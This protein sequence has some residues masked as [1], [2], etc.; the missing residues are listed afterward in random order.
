MNRIIKFALYLIIFYALFIVVA[1]S[2]ALIRR[3]IL[4][5]MFIDT[6]KILNNNNIT[7]W[8]DFG[9][10]LGIHRDQNI[11]LGDNDVDICI[12]ISQE[13]KVYQALKNSSVKW[14]RMHWPAFRV[15]NWGFWVDLYL[16]TVDVKKSMVYIPDSMD[17]PLS[18]FQSLETVTM[19]VGNHMVTFN[20][21]AVWK[22]LLIFRYGQKWTDRINK[23]YLGY[24]TFLESKLP[25]N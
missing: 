6:V 1:I 2:V 13:D 12:P 25:R 20:Q 18:Y 10:L 7:Y 14:R 8:V 3:N 23:W 21:P 9:T 11:I 16:V 15:Y 19:P 4:T 24:L 5:S 22:N 17:T